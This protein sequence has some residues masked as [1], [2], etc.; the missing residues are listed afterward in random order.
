MGNRTII[1]FNHDLSPRIAK[2]PAVF[3]ELFDKASASGSDK[4]WEALE[5]FGVKRI[6]QCHSS[7]QRLLVVGYPQRKY[8]FG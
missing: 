5:Y 6:T 3:A 7:E 8:K 4:D 2:Y 1:D